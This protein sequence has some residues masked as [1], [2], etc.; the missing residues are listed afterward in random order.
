[1]F[2]TRAIVPGFG[3]MARMAEPFRLLAANGCEWIIHP[4]VDPDGDGYVRRADVEV[5]ADGMAARTTATLSVIFEKID[6]GVFFAGLASDWR[7]WKGER[8]W[9]ALEREMAIDARHDG[10]ANVMIAVTVRRAERTYAGDVWPA[11]VVFTVEAGE[12]L[13]TLASDIGSLL[14]A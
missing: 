8:R 12:Q 2:I 3:I 5:R 6:L 11:R 13:A 4:P 14:A 7:G 1:M 9:E 10:R